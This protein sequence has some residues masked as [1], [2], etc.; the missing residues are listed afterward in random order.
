MHFGANLF[1]NVINRRL[2]PR[3]NLANEGRDAVHF[4]LFLLLRNP[5]S[6]ILKSHGLLRDPP[7]CRIKGGDSLTLTRQPRKI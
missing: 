4:Q 3:T 7:E 2:L 5:T 1:K 6:C